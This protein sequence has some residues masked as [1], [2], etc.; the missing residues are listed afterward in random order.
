MNKIYWYKC[1]KSDCL[2]IKI[3]YECFGFRLKSQ[4]LSSAQDGDKE[5][6]KCCSINHEKCVIYDEIFIIEIDSVGTLKGFN[7]FSPLK[8]NLNLN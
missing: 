4:Q 1:R 2:L 7:N 5:Y 6:P 8:C 3:V